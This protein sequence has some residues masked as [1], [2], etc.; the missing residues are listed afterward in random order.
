[1]THIDVSAD[2]VVALG[3]QLTDLADMVGSDPA[4]VTL[5]EGLPPGATA[6]ALG[7]VLG[8]WSRQRRLLAGDLSG[9]AALAQTAAAAYLW[10]E[11]TNED[12]FDD[13]RAV[14]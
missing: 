6:S 5:H 8:G 4:H 12:A 14:R 13:R 7:V 1:M 9:L 11:T 2:A 3:E 10:V